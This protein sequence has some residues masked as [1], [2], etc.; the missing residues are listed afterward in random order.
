MDDLR[1]Q[2]GTGGGTLRLDEALVARG[3]LASRSRARDAIL[4][5]CVK[6]DGQIASKPGLKASPDSQI[7]LDD[8]AGSYVARS[9]LKLVAGLD[10]FGFDVRG[11]SALD[12]G[13]S[14]G[15]F[16]E[17]LLQRG[18]AHV[19]AL[20]V[21][22]GQ[23]HPKIAGDPRVTAIERTNARDLTRQQLAGHPIE[24][25]VCDVSFIS[26]TI[27]L[28]AALSLAESGA[29]ALFLVKPQFEAGR[30]AI[31]KGGLLRDPEMAETVANQIRNWLDGMAGW[32]TLGLVP[33]PI[34][35]GDGNRE[36]LLGARKDP[37]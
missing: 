7:V 8:P 4:R 37:A 15:G 1:P 2:A 20:D 26:L 19:I 35:G 31:G 18:A 12:L 29:I 27:A 14:T 24:V 9:A 17:V 6:L 13:A 3:L 23:L 32:Q 30:E 36:F 22:R 34:E 25:L 16:T 5:G 21:G 28:P 33:S 11:R 10:A